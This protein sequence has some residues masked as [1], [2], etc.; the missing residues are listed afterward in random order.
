M[1]VAHRAQ[2]KVPKIGFDHDQIINADLQ[3]AL[4]VTL[5]RKTA[6]SGWNGCE[7]VTQSHVPL[8]P[9]IFQLCYM[10]MEEALLFAIS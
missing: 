9:L 1:D 4:F 2:S 7:P 3:N 8:S 6:V 10:W 5:L